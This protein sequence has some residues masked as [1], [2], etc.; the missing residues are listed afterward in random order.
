MSFFFLTCLVSFQFH[1]ALHVLVWVND[2]HLMLVPNMIRER[3]PDASIGFFLH[4]PFPSSEIFRC[5]HGKYLSRRSPSRETGQSAVCS[6][7]CSIALVFFLYGLCYQFFFWV[8][9]ANLLSVSLPFY[10]FIYFP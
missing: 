7:Y 8:N 3:L 4:I 2:Y 1:Y 9:G 6:V 5:L 10:T